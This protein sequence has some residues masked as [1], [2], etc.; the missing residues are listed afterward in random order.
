M[1]TQTELE[2]EVLALKAEL[3][4]REEVMRSL[5]D[6]LAAIFVAGS[7]LYCVSGL[8]VSRTKASAAAE[9]RNILA[10]SAAEAEGE[11]LALMRKIYPPSDGW[12]NTVFA[13]AVNLTFLAQAARGN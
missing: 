4:S 6:K 7:R 1:K 11:M 9:A 2:T 3:A 5:Q 12:V 13:S 8:A 10:G